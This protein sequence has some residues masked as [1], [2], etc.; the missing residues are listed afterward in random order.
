MDAY[1]WIFGI[2]SIILSGVLVGAGSAAVEMYNRYPEYKQG[3]MSTFYFV[4]SSVGLGIF[5]LIVTI[6]IMVIGGVTTK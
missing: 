4:S 6:L 2:L 3:N 1:G 5:C